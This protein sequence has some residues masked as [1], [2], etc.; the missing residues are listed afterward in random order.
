[1]RRGAPGS[2]PFPFPCKWEFSEFVTRGA[3]TD[4]H[5]WSSNWNTR[6]AL[7]EMVAVCAPLRA[8]PFVCAGGIGALL[9]DALRDGVC[10]E[11]G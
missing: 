6:E 1:M 3:R 8:F 5:Y 11:F 2:L 7:R 9:E 10:A 4:R